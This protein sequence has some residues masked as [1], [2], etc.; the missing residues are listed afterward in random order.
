LSPAQIWYVSYPD[1]VSS[2]ITTD[3]S[4]YSGA[5]LTANGKT[6][7]TTGFDVSQQLYVAPNGDTALARQIPHGTGLGVGFDWMPDGR[8]VYVSR[9]SGKQDLWVMDADGEHPKQLTHSNDGEGY[10][11]PSVSPDGRYIVCKARPSGNV[12]RMDIDGGHL[13]QLTDKT[14]DLP[15]FS[16]DGKWVIYYTLS[17][18]NGTMWRVPLEGGEPEQLSKPDVTVVAP[19]VSPNGKLI[20]CRYI[21]A[22]QQSKRELEQMDIAIL[23]FEGSEPVR[24]FEPPGG[25]LYG[26]G[27]YPGGIFWMPD[28][29]AFMYFQERDGVGNIWSQPLDGSA[30]R[31]ITSFTADRILAAK[32]SR[33][34]K[35]LAIVR[36]SEK[37]DV[38]RITFGDGK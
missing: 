32:W 27:P 34:G 16:P 31:Q 5:S 37:G 11:S 38:I 29:R 19:M 1:G 4:T 18:D 17:N 23:P 12:W 7:L 22:N 3:L 33:D 6:L 14:G 20:A 28:S 26:H 9:A 21:A 10:G 25:I 15:I 8:I 35:Q 36:G 30:A 13:T 2:R 24:I